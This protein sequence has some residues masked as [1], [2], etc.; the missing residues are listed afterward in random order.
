MK[1]RPCVTYITHVERKPKKLQDENGGRK[2]GG[3]S[4]RVRKKMEERTVDC[5]RI[6]DNE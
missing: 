4:E 6:D 3:V 2:R 5:A 1:K